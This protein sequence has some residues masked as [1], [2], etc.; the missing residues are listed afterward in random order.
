MFIKMDKLSIN[1]TIHIEPLLF[2]E[3]SQICREIMEI[4]LFN[5]QHTSVL[6][7]KPQQRISNIYSKTCLK[8]PLKNRQFENKDLNDKW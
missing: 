1:I 3:K 2:E 8:R 5:H 6:K 7:A 4:L